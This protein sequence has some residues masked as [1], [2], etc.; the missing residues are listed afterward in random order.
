MILV[1]VP[2]LKLK[3][4]ESDITLWLCFSGDSQ[5]FSNSQWKSVGKQSLDSYIWAE[6]CIV[7]L[8]QCMIS[9]FIARI[10]ARY[11][12]KIKHVKW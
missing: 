1:V 4:D 5:I 6:L 9:V 11:N 12:F 10:V 3:D 8:H 7:F 2:P